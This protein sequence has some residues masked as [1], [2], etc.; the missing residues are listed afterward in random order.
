MGTRNDD[1][2][3]I[4]AKAKMSG[5]FPDVKNSE[6]DAIQAYA[7]ALFADDKS[8]NSAFVRPKQNTVVLFG[9]S[10]T[11]N[12]GGGTSW[13]DARGWFFWANTLL[14]G[15]LNILKNAGIGGNNTT[16]MVGR[17]QTD[18][19]DYN[20]GWVIVMAGTNDAVQDVAA[21]TIISNLTT[22][23]N[24]IIANGGKVVALT[25][26]PRT[27]LT[28]Y[29]A[30]QLAKVNKWIKTY[31]QTARGVYVCD[32]GAALVDTTLPGWQIVA[33]YATDGLHPNATGAMR[34]GVALAATLDPI[35]PKSDILMT[36]ADVDNLI[37]NPYFNGSGTAAPANWG[38]QGPAPLISYVPRTDGISGSWLQVQVANGAATTNV[39]QNASLSSEVGIGDTVVF[40]VEVQCDTLDPSPAAGTQ[41]FGAYLLCNNGSGFTIKGYAPYWESGY[42]NAPFPGGTAVFTTNPI[43]IPAG[44]TFIQPVIA[45]N[46]GG[47]YR[48]HR[49]TL[50]KV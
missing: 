45:M 32:V 35:I 28:G 49:A 10:I 33:A 15:R 25:I 30:T 48:M 7:D 26:M 21:A 19:L 47:K 12:N 31:G 41:Q 5:F 8:L 1:F 36:G 24:K 3:L 11:Y 38:T 39:F 43:I 6:L 23:Y 16:Q 22:I 46:G 2:S 40:S 42:G 27:G 44:T 37:L 29:Q 9:D 17:I 50:R 14:G 13:W 4:L 34:T 18:V 20:P